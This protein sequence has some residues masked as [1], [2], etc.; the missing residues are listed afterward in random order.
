MNDDYQAYPSSDIRVLDGLSGECMSLDEP[1]QECSTDVSVGPVRKAS[2]TASSARFA[3]LSGPASGGMEWRAEDTGTILLPSFQSLCPKRLSL[4]QEVSEQEDA[5]VKTERQTTLD[6][7]ARSVQ[8]P[9]RTKSDQEECRPIQPF[10]VESLLQ[11]FDSNKALRA[12]QDN[13]ARQ[14]EERIRSAEIAHGRQLKQL[15]ALQQQVSAMQQAIRVQ[16]NNIGVD[17]TAYT[18]NRIAQQQS[19]QESEELC[20]N[21]SRMTAELRSGGQ[22]PHHLCWFHD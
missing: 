14:L 20:A 15:A 11:Q 19:I 9:H 18:D 1:L 12:E 22:G 10:T 6:Y 3:N 8:S 7:F 2:T 17:K 5:P 16:R 21:L 4:S 13:T